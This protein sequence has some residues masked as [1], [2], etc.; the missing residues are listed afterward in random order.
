MVNSQEIIER[1]IYSALLG[2]AVRL[3][4]TVD[5][6]LYLPKSVQNA[7]KYQADIDKLDKFVAIFGTGENQAKGKK[8]QKLSRPPSL[9]SNRFIW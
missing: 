1:S 3:G 6:N 5:P 7:A 2:V 9:P 8:I 4:K